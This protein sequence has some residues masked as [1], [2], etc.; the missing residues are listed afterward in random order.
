M[1][2]PRS[3]RRSLGGQPRAV[4]EK[5][6]HQGPFSMTGP[7]MDHHAGSLV[8]HQQFVILI[9]NIEGHGLGCQTSLFLRTGKTNGNAVPPAEFLAGLYRQAIDQN[10]A[11]FDQGLQG[12]AGVGG[13]L[14]REKDVESL[15]GIRMFNDEE[16]TGKRL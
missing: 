8:D 2:D 12:I 7:G 5:T 9:E 4:D 14:I 1:D 13:E 15:S 11:R 16:T 10:F 3:K 6:V